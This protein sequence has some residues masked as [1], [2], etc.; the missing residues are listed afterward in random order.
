MIIYKGTSYIFSQTKY[1][2]LITLCELEI[3]IGEFTCKTWH[4]RALHVQFIPAPTSL[5]SK[6]T[7]FNRQEKHDM[8][9]ARYRLINI[10][11]CTIQL[12]YVI[13]CG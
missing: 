12:H 11:I 5:A 1:K 6:E 9:L 3:Q 13:F 2:N 7:F 10:P 4:D 8:L